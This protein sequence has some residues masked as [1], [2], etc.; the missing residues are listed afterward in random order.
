VPLFYPNVSVGSIVTAIGGAFAEK[1]NIPG[2]FYQRGNDFKGSKFFASLC[3][4]NNPINCPPSNF[5]GITPPN[6]LN[7]LNF[8]QTRQSQSAQNYKATQIVNTFVG[9]NGSNT[10][11]HTSVTTV[12]TAFSNGSFVVS[13]SQLPSSF[14]FP[15]SWD[16]TLTTLCT[17][18]T[19][20]GGTG[21]Q[22]NND[23]YVLPNQSPH[24]DTINPSSSCTLLHDNGAPTRQLI[25]SNSQILIAL[26]AS[27]VFSQ[28]AIDVNL[29]IQATS[30][31]RI[32]FDVL[33]ANYDDKAPITTATGALNLIGENSDNGST[34]SP[35]ATGLI[36][37]AVILV[38]AGGGVAF[39]FLYLRKKIAAMQGASDTSV[40]M[41]NV[42]M[43][44]EP[45]GDD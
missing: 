4:V 44:D 17:V 12:V 31:S 10:M 41:S 23:C 14:N 32:Q 3:Q 9:G 29:Q 22:A 13:N 15:F 16:Y 21:P 30:P 24:I 34:L 8:F 2:S 37:A 26:S 43:G 42:N 35:L 6:P 7:T 1:N 33:D 28:A 25:I 5:P 40:S 45:E 36:T 38:A 11:Y 27:G 19:F 39:Y 18:A 20:N